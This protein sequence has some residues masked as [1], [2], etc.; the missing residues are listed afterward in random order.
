MFWNHLL[1]LLIQNIQS[2]PPSK[3]RFLIQMRGS[4]SFDPMKHD[5]RYAQDILRIYTNNILVTD[6]HDIC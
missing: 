6:I 2:M 3:S 1:I 4:F 5:V